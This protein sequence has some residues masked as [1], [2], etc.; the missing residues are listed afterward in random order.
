MKNASKPDRITNKLLETAHALSKHN[1]LPA[2]QLNQI[3]ALSNV[4]TILLGKTAVQMQLG[5][6]PT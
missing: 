2:Q 6:I 1:V 4:A 5:T 3:R